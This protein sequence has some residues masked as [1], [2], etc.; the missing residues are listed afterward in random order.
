[1]STDPSRWH[2]PDADDLPSSPAADSAPTHSD[3]YQA[4]DPRPDRDGS[5]NEAD[6]AEQVQPAWREG[7]DDEFSQ[8]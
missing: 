1:M 7:D 6:V 3:E 8:E 5:A 2:E 4:P